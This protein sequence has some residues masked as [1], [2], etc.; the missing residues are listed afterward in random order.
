MSESISLRWNELPGAPEAG[1]I[2]AKLDII[3]DGGACLLSLGDGLK[4]YGVILL[5]SGDSVFAYVNRC[6]HFG[7]PLATK[8]EY[9]GSK[10]HQSIH[11]SV[12]YARYRWQDGLCD[13]GDCKGESLISIPV[14]VVGGDVVV[15]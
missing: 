6:A 8:V 12:H 7:V 13:F 14:N 2:L 10:P 3:A 1:F 4:P 5:R 9:L 11:C 15:A